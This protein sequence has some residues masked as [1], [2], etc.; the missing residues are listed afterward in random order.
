MRTRE[1]G[2]LKGGCTAGGCRTRAAAAIT[3]GQNAASEAE[4][5]GV[6]TGLGGLVGTEG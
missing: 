5:E 4:M 2:A 3:G 1:G 6:P